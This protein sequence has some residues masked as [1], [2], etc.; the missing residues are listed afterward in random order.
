MCSVRQSFSQEACEIS[1]PVFV[2]QAQSES[3]MDRMSVVFIHIANET[4][5][6]S[7]DHQRS[8]FCFIQFVCLCVVTGMRRSCGSPFPSWETACVTP[9]PPDPWSGWAA[10]GSPCRKA[11]KRPNR[12]CTRMASWSAKSTPTQTARKVRLMH[13]KTQIHALPSYARLIVLFTP[14][15]LL[16]LI[17]LQTDA[18][19][20]SF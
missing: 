5:H 11:W 10:A 13:A 1:R 15:E 6:M 2:S 16:L 17:P 12:C 19:F 18:G 20:K 14:F 7:G 9:T 8:L 3:Q 4:W